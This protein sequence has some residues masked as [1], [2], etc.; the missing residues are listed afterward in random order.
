M[1]MAASLSVVFNRGPR[2]TEQG[3][4]PIS[5]YLIA[6]KTASYFLRFFRNLLTALSLMVFYSSS[7]RSLLTTLKSSRV[8]VSCVIF[9]TPAATSRSSLRMILP[10]RVFGSPSAKRT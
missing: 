2:M 7:C 3:D 4:S 8:D 1:N 6:S 5:E 10:L 9:S